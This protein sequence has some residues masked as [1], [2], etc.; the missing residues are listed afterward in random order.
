MSPK[1]TIIWCTVISMFSLIT[2]YYGGID[3]FVASGLNLVAIALASLCWNE[4][5][6]RKVK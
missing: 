1:A 6:A 4:L 5:Q 2:A 3:A